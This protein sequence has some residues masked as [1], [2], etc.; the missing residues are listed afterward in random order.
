[1]RNH[2]TPL[3]P[4]DPAYEGEDQWGLNKIEGPR[5]WGIITGSNQVIVA[6]IDSGVDLDHPDLQDKIVA[7]W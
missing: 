7:G 6:V 4:N 1:M 2:V 3:Y 5:A